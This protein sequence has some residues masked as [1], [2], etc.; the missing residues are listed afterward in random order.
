MIHR[1]KSSP[2][3]VCQTEYEKVERLMYLNS[4]VD[5]GGESVGKY[6]KDWAKC[7]STSLR[8]WRLVMS[9][10]FSYEKLWMLKLEDRRRADP[11]KIKAHK[12]ILRPVHFAS[13]LSVCIGC[14]S[15]MLSCRLCFLL[16]FEVTLKFS[17]HLAL[18]KFPCECLIIGYAAA[19][20]YKIF[21]CLLY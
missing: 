19:F 10:S 21:K 20:N 9:T 12:W 16:P 6:W 13:H 1:H 18:F 7:R 4:L 15:P 3:T 5:N 2:S 14:V 17:S 11:F 8:L